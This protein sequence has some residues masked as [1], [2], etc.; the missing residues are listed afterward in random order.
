MK[1]EDLIIGKII[2]GVCGFNIV[3]M[4]LVTGILLAMMTCKKKDECYD[5]RI[6]T[7]LL[8]FTAEKDTLLV[9]DTVQVWCNIDPVNFEK[10]N[11]Y[12]AEYPEQ[13]F[14]VNQIVKCKTKQP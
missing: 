2:T 10:I 12:H 11:T 5:C 9:C 14:N 8:F 6:T 13:G 7:Y 4:I 1:N 3:I